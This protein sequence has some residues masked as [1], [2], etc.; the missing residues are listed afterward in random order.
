MRN[1]V[2]LETAAMMPGFSPVDGRPMPIKE[3]IIPER[4]IFART[5]IDVVFGDFGA[6]GG[7]YFCFVVFFASLPLG[8]LNKYY[9]F[10]CFLCVLCGLARFFFVVVFFVAFGF[11][12]V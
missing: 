12:V 2:Y 6:F 10:C 7:D 4:T 5:Q 9:L 1:G 8:V 11:F 3:K